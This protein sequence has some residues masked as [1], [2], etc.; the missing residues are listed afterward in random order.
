MDQPL[1]PVD[2]PDLMAEM[3]NDFLVFKPAGHGKGE[4]GS[5]FPIKIFA[6]MYPVVSRSGFFA[7]DDN[8]ELT[9]NSKLFAEPVPDHSVPDNDHHGEMPIAHNQ[10]I[11]MG[12]MAGNR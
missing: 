6:E 7:K 8:F 2:L 11:W 4:V 5:G 9:G 3:K 10:S 1:L 12:K